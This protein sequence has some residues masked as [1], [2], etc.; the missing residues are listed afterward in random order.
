MATQ[1]LAAPPARPRNPLAPD[2]YER[3]LAAASVVLLGSVAMALFKG[4]PH[5][6]QVPP[7][8]WF[9]IAT[10]TVA[11]GLTPAMLLRARGDRW[12]R[13]LGWIWAG[14][15]MVTALSTF[16]IRT[17]HPGRLWLIHILSAWTAIQVPLLIWHARKHNSAAHRRS[18]RGMVTGALI[19]AGIFTFPFGRLM[20][21][22]LFG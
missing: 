2:S 15:M 12:H 22:W 13:R 14:A 10:I 17:I 19:I 11:L 1:T 9:H 5:W 8:V 20:G 3:V 21:R 6:G 4:R 7:I 16:A 18:V